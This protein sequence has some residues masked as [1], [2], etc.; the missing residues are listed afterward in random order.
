MKPWIT[1]AVALAIACT[2]AFR[3][4]SARVEEQN[5]ETVATRESAWQKEKAELAAALKKAG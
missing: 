1:A 2:I 3:V 4:I 5:A